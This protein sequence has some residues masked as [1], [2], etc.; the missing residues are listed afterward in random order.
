MGVAQIK[1]DR[2]A[3]FVVGD[4]KR[5]SRACGEVDMVIPDVL[6]EDGVHDGD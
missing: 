6:I 1:E 3:C 2:F 4:G 5:A